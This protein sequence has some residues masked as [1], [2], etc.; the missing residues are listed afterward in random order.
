MRINFAVDVLLTDAA[1]NQL[2]VL[3]PE[4]Q[5][6]DSFL[7]RGCCVGVGGVRHGNREY[8]SLLQN[9]EYNSLL[10]NREY[11]SLLQ[12]REYNSLLQ[13]REYNSLLQL[14]QSRV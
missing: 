11:N 1:G 5:N 12:N 9:R 14:W 10:Q 3:R 8:N 4:I 2:R 13:N 6:E 7:M